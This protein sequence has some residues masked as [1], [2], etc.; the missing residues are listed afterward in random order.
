MC[1]CLSLF[2]EQDMCMNGLYENHTQTSDHRQ[3]PGGAC[4]MK[5]NDYVEI[6][7]GLCKDYIG[8]ARIV[9]KPRRKL[10]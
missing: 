2:T 6:M 7:S 8:K 4:I 3:M 10:F 1:V 5:K 9:E